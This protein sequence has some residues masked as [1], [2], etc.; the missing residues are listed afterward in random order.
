VATDIARHRRKSA[1]RET[2]LFDDEY[3]SPV[4]SNLPNR[5]N[6]RVRFRSSND[7]FEHKVEMDQEDEEE[8]EAQLESEP[9]ILT[10][11]VVSA[12]EPNLL[13]SLVRRLS[14][15]A[16]ILAIAISITHFGPSSGGGHP[17]LGATGVPTAEQ[18]GPIFDEVLSKRDSSPTDYCKRWSQQSMYLFWSN[19]NKLTMTGALVNGT[20]YLYG[21]RATTS[22]SQTSNTWS[23][24]RSM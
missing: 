21:G 8:C 2:G 6:L 13:S 19:Q 23:M 20:L 22:S 4:P 11:P 16:L 18:P 10:A 3:D 17:I 14:L 15:V 5:P 1:F 9:T 24:Y 12:T 7:V